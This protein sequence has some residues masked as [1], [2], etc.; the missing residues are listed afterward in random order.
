MKMSRYILGKRNEEGKLESIVAVP[1]SPFCPFDTSQI[2]IFKTRELAETIRKKDKKTG[3][4]VMDSIEL[5]IVSEEELNY[6]ID[7]DN[8]VLINKMEDWEN[9]PSNI[10]IRTPSRTHVS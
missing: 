8:F 6:E 9:R 3:F 7:D 10:F 2:Y 5:G 4:K 1:S